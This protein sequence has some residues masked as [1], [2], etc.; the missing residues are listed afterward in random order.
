MRGTPERQDSMFT[1]VSVE[2]RVPA[3]HPLRPIKAYAD[4]AL[5][6]LSRTFEQMYSDKAA[7]RFRRSDS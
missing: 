2:E 7:L 5:K 6:D 1:Y 4:S 3:D